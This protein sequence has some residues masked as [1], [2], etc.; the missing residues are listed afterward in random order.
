M[1]KSEDHLSLKKSRRGQNLALNKI[2]VWIN[3]KGDGNIRTVSRRMFWP[4]D[5]AN[6]GICRKE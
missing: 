4:E 2:F 3:E 1:E 6:A 5:L